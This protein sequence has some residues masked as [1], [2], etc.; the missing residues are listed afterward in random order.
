[1]NTS[2]VGLLSA[3]LLLTGFP[4]LLLAQGGGQRVYE[5]RTYTTVEGRLEAL[6]ARFR[7]HT[8]KLFEKH[9][10]TNVGYWVPQDEPASKNTLIYIISHRSREAAKKSWDAFRADPEW[11]KVQAESE[12][13]GKIVDKVVSVFMTATDYSK[14]K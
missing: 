3:A 10:M 14:L 2:S 5:L 8:I 12:K 9:G 6:Q 11:K 1:M 4:S 7:D 13:D